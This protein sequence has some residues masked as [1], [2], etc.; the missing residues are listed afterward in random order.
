MPLLLDSQHAVNLSPAM[1]LMVEEVGWRRMPRVFEH[2]GFVFYINDFSLGEIGIEPI[3]KLA[4][5]IVLRETGRPQ[6][7][8]LANSVGCRLYA[9]SKLG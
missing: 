5:L 1:R 2:P 9:V 6:Y 4:N 7:I 3:N 8:E